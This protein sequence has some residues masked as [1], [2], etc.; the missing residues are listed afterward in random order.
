MN[1]IE[2]VTGLP[3]LAWSE[4]SMK[5]IEMTGAE[6]VDLSDFVWRIGNV[7]MAGFIYSSL[8]APPWMWFVLAEGVTMS[9]LIDFRRLSIGIPIGTL[10]AVAVDFPVAQKFARVYGFEPTGEERVYYNRT[11]ELMRKV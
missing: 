10:T 4:N 11:Y 3:D 5:E 7:A 6:L 8:L 1:R 9:D 2:L